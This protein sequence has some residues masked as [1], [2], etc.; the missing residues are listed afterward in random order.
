MIFV[1]KGNIMKFIEGKFKDWGYEM[2]EWEYGDKVFIW[3]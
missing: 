2:V 1:Y 3:V